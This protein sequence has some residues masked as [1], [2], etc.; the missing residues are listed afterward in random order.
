MER[1]Q[2]ISW[3]KDY[4]Q[5]NFIDTNRSVKDQRKAKLMASIQDVGFV[6]NPIIVNEKYS[7]TE[8]CA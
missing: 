4:D 1:E 5:F 8:G 7:R 6:T 2:R 3:T